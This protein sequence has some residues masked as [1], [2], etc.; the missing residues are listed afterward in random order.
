MELNITGPEMGQAKLCEHILHALPQWFGIET[1]IVNYLSEIEGLPT[2]LACRSDYVVGF[3]TIKQHYS[4]SAEILVMGVLPEAHR[5]G[6]GKALIDKAEAWLKS[7]QIEYLQVK[8][9]GPSNNDTN[10]SKTRAFY[11]SLGFRPL[12][13]FRQIWNEQNPCL[14]L[15]KRI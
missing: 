11:Q 9:L 6:I 7:R 8:T 5:Q 1:A 4:Y 2:F 14:I 15:V 3:L 12:E 10:Y 13:E